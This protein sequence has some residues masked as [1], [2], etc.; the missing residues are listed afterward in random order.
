MQSIRLRGTQDALEKEVQTD[1]VFVAIGLEP[2]N[3]AFSDVVG[4][5]RFG[6]I[7]ADESCCTST[8]GV[9][10]AGDARTK[11]LRQIITAAADG[12]GAAKQAFE[13][14]KTFKHQA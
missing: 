4:T 6:Y 10:V 11:K 13:Y 12:A 5:D 3:S 1:A 7:V 9:F 2:Q 8:D 14:I